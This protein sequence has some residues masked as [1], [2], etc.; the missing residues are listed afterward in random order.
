M[1]EGIKGAD[2]LIYYSKSGPNVISPEQI[3]LVAKDAM[4]LVCANPIPE[5]CPWECK[6]AG[7]RI[8]TTRRP[9]FAKHQ[10]WEN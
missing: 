3:K 6:E 7:A 1:T 4:C 8:V 9:D 5:I 2:T 10:Q